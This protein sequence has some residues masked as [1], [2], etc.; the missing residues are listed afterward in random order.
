[1]K[2]I[3]RMTG[4][5]ASNSRRICSGVIYPAG[6]GLYGLLTLSFVTESVDR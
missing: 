1:M 3:I 2:L 6:T 4:S 5:A